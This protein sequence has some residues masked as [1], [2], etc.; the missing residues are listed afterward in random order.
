MRTDNEQYGEITPA[1]KS[2]Y[3][4]DLDSAE[5]KRALQSG[6]TTACFTPGSANVVGGMCSVFRTHGVSRENMMMRES[7][8]VRAALGQDV[9]ASNSSFRGAGSDLDNIFGRR[10]NSRM[11]TVWELRQALFQRERYPALARAAA[12]VIPLRIHA[13]TENDIRVVFTLMD[14]FKL[15]NVILDDATEAHKIADQL[16]ARRI[17]VVLGPLAD[18]QIV[19]TEGTESLLNTAGLLASKGVRIAFGSSGGD[20]T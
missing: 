1:I 2:A 17:P 16:A 9:Y 18:P 6:V 19:S 7:H 13:R 12:G 8:A 5:L 10:P 11:A 4:I 14:E 3:L 20:P 15:K